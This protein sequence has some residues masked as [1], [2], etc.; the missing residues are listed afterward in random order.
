MTARLGGVRSK[1]K[2]QCRTVTGTLAAR[3][4]ISDHATGAT[5]RR[6]IFPFMLVHSTRQRRD[7]DGLAAEWDMRSGM[8]ALKAEGQGGDFEPTIQ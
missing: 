3:S 6:K 8:A 5:S 2:E 1:L 4:Q 7:W